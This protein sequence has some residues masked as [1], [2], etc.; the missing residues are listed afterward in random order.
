MNHQHER[1]REL[2]LV[3]DRGVIEHYRL[4]GDLLGN[5]WRTGLALIEVRAIV[6]TKV[7]D[8]FPYAANR[9]LPLST[10]YRWIMVAERNPDGVD[11][12]RS[13]NEA[14]G[15]THPKKSVVPHEVEAM[16]KKELVKE[17]LRLRHLDLELDQLRQELA[18]LR[19]ERRSGI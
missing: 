15:V 9:G 19:R 14:L 4:T 6:G 13:I 8:W 18:I 3:I 1:L 7:D 16:T 17:V 10:A 5:A 2:A 11:R 12:Y